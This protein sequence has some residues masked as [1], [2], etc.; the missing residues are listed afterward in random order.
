[1]EISSRDSPPWE[2]IEWR[3]LRLETVESQGMR[4]LAKQLSFWSWEDVDGC[5]VVDLCPVLV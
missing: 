5:G 1:M 4:A 3:P 2:M